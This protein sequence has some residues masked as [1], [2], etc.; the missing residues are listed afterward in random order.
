MKYVLHTLMITIKSQRTSIPKIY[1]EVYYMGKYL[2][3]P[4]VLFHVP[5]YHFKN[6]HLLHYSSSLLFDKAYTLVN[7]TYDLTPF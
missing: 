5:F 6:I 7:L 2:H 4:S 1:I 3:D